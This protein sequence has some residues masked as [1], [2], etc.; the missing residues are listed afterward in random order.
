MKFPMRDRVRP[1]SEKA[2]RPTLLRDFLE[3]FLPPRWPTSSRA[4]GCWDRFVAD[5][6]RKCEASRFRA[7]LRSLLTR[8]TTQPPRNGAAVDCLRA[9]P[10]SE[11]RR[12]GKE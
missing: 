5:E 12:V 4:S 1:R 7:R 9:A 6:S 3:C 10:R 2:F 11:E 8:A